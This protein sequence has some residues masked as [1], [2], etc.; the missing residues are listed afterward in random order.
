[1]PPIAQTLGA[2]SQPWLAPTHDTQCASPI[3]GGR[4]TTEGLR[5]SCWHSTASGSMGSRCGVIMDTLC[6]TAQPLCTRCQANPR[7]PKQR[8][9]R[10]CLT[11]AQRERRAAQSAAQADEAPAP[12]THARRQAMPAV[13]QAPVPVRPAAAQGHTEAHQHAEEPIQSALSPEAA[14]ALQH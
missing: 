3:C 13:T 9:C 1:M 14:R 7:L 4:R 2:T 8:W 11:A 6:N 12:V 10:Q 5:P